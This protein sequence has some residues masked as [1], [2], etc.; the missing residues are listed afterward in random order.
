MNKS[1]VSDF[2]SVKQTKIDKE[3]Q[4]LEV[5]DVTKDERENWRINIENAADEASSL[6]GTAAV[7]GV[8]ARY[9]ATCFDDLSPSYY[10]EVFGDLEMMASDN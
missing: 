7:G 2:R 8:F 4:L 3:K 6:H 10:W 1:T 5:I 9:D